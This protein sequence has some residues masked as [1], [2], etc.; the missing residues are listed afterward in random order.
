MVN[1]ILGMLEADNGTAIVEGFTVPFEGDM[2]WSEAGLINLQNE[3]RM[4]L[5]HKDL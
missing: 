2:Y 3:P 1:Q 4:G 5:P